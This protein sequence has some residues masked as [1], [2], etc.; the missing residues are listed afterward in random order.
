VQENRKEQ[1]LTQ[2]MIDV[3]TITKLSSSLTPCINEDH[4]HS[5]F[6]V[7]SLEFEFE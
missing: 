7:T 4:F 3:D 1:R 6:L 2:S 5:F